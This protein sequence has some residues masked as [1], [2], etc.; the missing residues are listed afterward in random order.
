MTKSIESVSGESK[1]NAWFKVQT[2]LWFQRYQCGFDGLQQEFLN[3]D[4]FFSLLQ[5]YR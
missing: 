2:Q 3:D 1:A 5:Q 4:T